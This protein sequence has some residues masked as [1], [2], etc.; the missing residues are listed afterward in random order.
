MTGI[1]VFILRIFLAASLFV[2]IGIMFIT[3]WRQLKTQLKLLSPEINNVLRL[4]PVETEQIDTIEIKQAEVIVGRDPNNKIYI[5]DETISAQHCRIYISDQQWWINDLNSTNGTY[6]N[7]EIIDRP[8]VMT[9]GDMIMFGQ[10]KFSI[11]IIN[12]SG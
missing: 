7:D 2:F 5:P 10:V 12:T 3:I 9:D 6:L 1:V 8:C 4:I 11:Q